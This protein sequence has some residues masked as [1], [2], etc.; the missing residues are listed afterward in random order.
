MQTRLGAWAYE[1]AGAPGPGALA[2]VLLH[3]LLMDRSMWAGQRDALAALTRT[4]A[5]DGP[6][7][8]ESPPAPPFTLETQADV[9]DDALNTLGVARAIVVGHSWGGMVGLRLAL[10]HPARVA[11]LALIDTSARAERAAQRLKYA[12]LIALYRIFGLPR[13]LRRSQI[14]PLLFGPRLLRSEPALLDD[15]LR[16]VNGA[17]RGGI[18][19]AAAAVM[20]DRSD[21][22]SAVGRI[23]A[24]ALILCGTEDRSTPPA[25]ARE[26]GA[27]IAGARVEWVEGCGHTPPL[28]DPGRV[29]DLLV[30][31]VAR[32][33]ESAATRSKG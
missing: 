28:E 8:G 31:F 11:A 9:L 25:C 21:V 2:V 7:H 16:R 1:E 12:A 26:L 14:A 23:S 27:A 30:G 15:L 19:R 20:V 33:I 22:V 10:R 18:S 17:D 24:P 4:I 6:G 32:Q 29:A 13:W 5:F 3:G